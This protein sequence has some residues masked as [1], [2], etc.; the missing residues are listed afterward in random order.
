MINLT[1]TFHPIGQGAFYT[2]VFKGGTNS[3]FVT[4][5]DC[6][7]ET[8]EASMDVSLNDQIDQFK[9]S[10]GSNPQIDLLFI[11]HFHADHINGLNRLLSGIRVVKTIIPMLDWPTIILTRVQNYLR[12][13]RGNPAIIE[14]ADQIISDLYLSERINNDKYG[15]VI[16]VS[17]NTDDDRGYEDQANGAIVRN[18]SSLLSGNKIIGNRFWEYIPFNSISF[19]DSRSRTLLD[20]LLRLGGVEDPAHLNLNTLLRDHL[21]DVE[22][23]YEKAIGNRK[24]NLYSL[25]VESKP[26]DGVMPEPAPRLSDCVYFGDFEYKQNNTLWDRFNR[27]INYSGVGT[28][29]V[30]HHGAKSNWRTEM[31]I[32]DPRHYII[33]SGSTNG[34]HHPS[35]W[36]IEEIWQK[37]HRPFVV[38]EKWGSKQVYRFEIY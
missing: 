36:V 33:S 35:Y 19:N 14:S 25:V 22:K 2:E 1:R 31:G 23:E 10:L 30:P 5:Y 7:S 12:F 11:S 34:Y 29:Q 6:G 21:D 20:G 15:K 37:G 28:V 16:I 13:H 17:P 3:P 24:H 38:S 32:G 8:A 18:G 4:V 26:V 9:S 27:A